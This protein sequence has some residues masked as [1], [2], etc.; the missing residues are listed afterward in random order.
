[1]YF[2][3]SNLLEENTPSILGECLKL[4]TYHIL[5]ILHNWYKFGCDRSATKCTLFEEQITFSAVSRL[6]FQGSISNCT[7]SA[8]APQLV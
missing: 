3:F 1:M 4:L 2:N 7:L 6:L 5:R 8:R